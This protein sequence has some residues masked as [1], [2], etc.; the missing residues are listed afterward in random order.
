MYFSTR[1]VLSVS[2]LLFHVL[3]G[4]GVV[5]F[6]PPM[7]APAPSAGFGGEG[8][9]YLIAPFPMAG[10]AAFV[11]SSGTGERERA[12][13]A[14]FCATMRRYRATTLGAGTGTGVPG[15]MSGFLFS[16]VFF[17]SVVFGDL[18]RTL[19]PMYSAVGGGAW[20]TMGL[21][22]TAL[23]SGFSPTGGRRYGDSAFG[24]LG[25]S[26]MA[27]RFGD[28]ATAGLAFAFGLE[29]FESC[30]FFSFSARRCSSF[31]TFAFAAT[32]SLYTLIP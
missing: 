5:R 32:R 27:Y 29:I 2:V 24:D 6:A 20:T 1:F 22:A 31:W 19:F 12:R 30:S 4:D 11:P 8:T 10:L 18:S 16:G 28:S 13:R 23:R 14:S 17:F 21:G 3:G 9:L 25:S 7:P 15:P 26:L